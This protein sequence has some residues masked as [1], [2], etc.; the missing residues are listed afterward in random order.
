MKR[1]LLFTALV[2]S[3]TFFL[4]NGSASSS[5]SASSTTHQVSDSDPLKR[6]HNLL[7]SSTEGVAVEPGFDLIKPLNDAISKL[8]EKQKKYVLSA[9]EVKRLFELKIARL[10]ITV[11]YARQVSALPSPSTIELFRSVSALQHERL[12]Y[13]S[14]SKELRKVMNNVPLE[15]T[16][17]LQMI[18][19]CQLELCPKLAEGIINAPDDYELIVVQSALAGLLSVI[20]DCKE[21]AN[22]MWNSSEDQKKIIRKEEIIIHT[23]RELLKTLDVEE[24]GWLKESNMYFAKR[25]APLKEFVSNDP[26]VTQLQERK[27]EKL[28]AIYQLLRECRDIDTQALIDSDP[29]AAFQDDDDEEDEEI[30]RRN[31]MT[32]GVQS[33]YDTLETLIEHEVLYGHIPKETLQALSLE[34]LQQM[35]DKNCSNDAFLA[36]RIGSLMGEVRKVR[37]KGIEN[38]VDYIEKLKM[39][40]SSYLDEYTTREKKIV[41]LKDMAEKLTV[42]VQKKGGVE[43]PS[44][45]SKLFTSK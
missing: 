8:E 34:Q 27:R 40:K 20:E 17:S 15:M 31:V 35:Y 22:S 43:E 10:N 25:S 24:E 4:M 14:T 42:I 33:S 11:L 41:H 23:T 38:R 3:Q 7:V 13:F 30:D 1:L 26:K 37:Q 29:M 28:E 9:E 36:M 18:K 12:S 16:Q 21:T 5:T 19:S 39:V 32:A 44:F 2:A 6:A 45:W